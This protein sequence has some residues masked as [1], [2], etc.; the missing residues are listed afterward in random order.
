MEKKPLK[1]FDE[2]I[3]NSYN[4]LTIKQVYDFLGFKINIKSKITDVIKV[5]D[6]RYDQVYHRGLDKVR[7]ESIIENF[8]KQAIGIITVSVRENGDLFIIDGVQ[9]IQ[10]MIVLGFGEN[11]VKINALHDLDVEEESKLFKIINNIKERR[12]NDSN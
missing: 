1:S 9:R 10:A 8:N 4:S 11:Q 12:E 6:L 3:S 7:I 5:N 2:I